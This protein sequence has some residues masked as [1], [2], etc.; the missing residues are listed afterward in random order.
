MAWVS[1]VIIMQLFKLDGRDVP[2][3]FQQP[4]V[5]KPVHPGLFG[6]GNETR[7]RDFHLGRVGQRSFAAPKDLVL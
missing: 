3:R 2:D 4:P 6:A 7:T 5:V 1:V